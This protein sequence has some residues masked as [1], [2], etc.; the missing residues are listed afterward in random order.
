MAYLDEPPDLEVQLSGSGPTFT[1]Q[2]KVKQQIRGFALATIMA[3]TPTWLHPSTNSPIQT[4]SKKVQS[5]AYMA[6]IR[7]LISVLVFVRHFSLPWQQNMDYGYGYQGHNEI[8]RLPYLRLLFAG[9]LVPTF[10]I[11]S[12]YVLSIKSL[13]LSNSSSPTWENITLSLAGSAFRRGLRL[14]LPPILSTLGVMILLRAGLFSFPYDTMPGRIPDHPVL[15]E[16]AFQQLWDWARFVLAEMTNPWRWDSGALI[17][18]PHLWTIPISFRGSLVTFLMCLALLRVK[19]SVRLG[20]LTIGI[21]H[22]VLL[23]RWDMSLFL[24]GMLL[25]GVDAHKARQHHEQARSPSTIQADGLPV[26]DIHPRSLVLLLIGGFI[27]SFPRSNHH[28]HCVIGYQ[29][30]CNLTSDYHYWHALGAFLLTWAI[31]QDKAIQ[32]VMNTSI[33]Q[34]LGKISFSMYIIHEPLLH[35]FGFFTVPF[36]WNITGSRTILQYQSGFILGMATNLFVLIWLA[37]MFWRYIEVRCGSISNR[38]ERL[39][40]SV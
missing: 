40:F 38:I 27:A 9:P 29:T 39:F 1:V 16:T 21:V 15:L 33:A 10:F 25:S 35:V 18:G 6:G 12:G 14:F 5:T 28:G 36:F 23:G 8:L 3:L 31:W 19:S 2:T 22:S 34:Y 24:G 30:L 20:I 32:R 4:K 26:Y 37:D 7:G 11:L 13:Q 17:Y